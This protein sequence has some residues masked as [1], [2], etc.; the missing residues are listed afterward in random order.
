MHGRRVVTNCEKGEKYVTHPIR[1]NAARAFNKNRTL[2]QHDQT[3]SINPD[4]TE[5]EKVQHLK[6]I[7]LF[8]LISILISKSTSYPIKSWSLP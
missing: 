3:P 8:L 2:D 4:Y 6:L 1:G 5:S 7:L